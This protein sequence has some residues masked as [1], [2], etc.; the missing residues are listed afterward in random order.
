M[1]VSIEEHGREVLDEESKTGG[2]VKVAGG[3]G[4]MWVDDRPGIRR[5]HI[6]IR[7]A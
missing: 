5:V 4:W 1:G 6:L 2:W 7:D 3:G